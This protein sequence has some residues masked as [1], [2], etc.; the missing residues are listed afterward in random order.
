MAQHPAL[1]SD[2]TPS[3][4][5]TRAIFS[6]ASEYGRYSYRRITA[7]LRRAGWAVGKDGRSCE[8]SA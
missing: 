7:L 3:D 8:A 1:P 5:L 2:P 4:E 6:L